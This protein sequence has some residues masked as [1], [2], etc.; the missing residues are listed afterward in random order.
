M[1][2]IGENSGLESWEFTEEMDSKEN[3]WEFEDS[4]HYSDHMISEESSRRDDTSQNNISQLN[5]ATALAM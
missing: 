4:V 3:S 1:H 5:D 2:S